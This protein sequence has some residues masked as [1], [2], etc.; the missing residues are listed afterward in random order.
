MK[1]S[2]NLEE[3]QRPHLASSLSEQAY[4]GL[5]GAVSVLLFGTDEVLKE[6][7]VSDFL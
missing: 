3:P 7:A 1:V 2:T 4:L 5:E 6:V